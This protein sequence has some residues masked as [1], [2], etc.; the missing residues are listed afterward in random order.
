MRLERRKGPAIVAY[1]LV[2]HQVDDIAAPDQCFGQ[3][4]SR[5]EMSP[6]P[7]GGKNDKP[8][9]FLGVKRHAFS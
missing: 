2:R 7:A 9:R 3:R 1:P 6:G 8:I 4:L 5:E